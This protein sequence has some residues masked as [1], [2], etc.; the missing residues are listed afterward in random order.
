MTELIKFLETLPIREFA[1]IFGIL[2][3]I[4][5]IIAVF[6]IVFVFLRLLKHH[7]KV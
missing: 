7:N 4:V 6:F 3:I 1:W 2:S 5:F